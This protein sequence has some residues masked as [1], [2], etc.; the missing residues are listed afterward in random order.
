MKK[1]RALVAVTATSLAAAAAVA[2]P[3][4]ATTSDAA[5]V[6][7]PPTTNR[8]L[9]NTS[10]DQTPKPFSF[11][12]TDPAPSLSMVT[13]VE[14]FYPTAAGIV[15]PSAPSISAPPNW[16]ATPQSSPDGSTQWVTFRSNSAVLGLVPGQPT[17]FTV[18]GVVHEPAS[19]SVTGTW[20]VEDSRDGGKTLLPTTP[21]EFTTTINTLEFVTPFAPIAPAGVTDRTGTAGE[22]ITY[23]VAVRNFAANPMTIAPTVTS[24]SNDVVTQPAAQSI[25]GDGATSSFTVPVT[26]GSAGTSVFLASLPDGA[27]TVSDSFTV[28]A[29]ADLSLS[30]LGPSRIGAGGHDLTVATT[31]TGTQALQ[32]TGA[33]LSAGPIVGTATAV[34]TFGGG[35]QATPQNFTFP[36]VVA[37]STPDNDYPTTV[38]AQVTDDN[39]FSYT[40]THSPANDVIVDTTAPSVNPPVIAPPKD[41]NGVAQS[42]TKNGDTLSISGVVG[43]VT[44][45]DTSSL[46]VSITPNDGSAARPVTS[47]GAGLTPAANNTYTYACTFSGSWGGSATSVVANVQVN[48]TAGNV[49][50][51]SGNS[52]AVSID[53]IAPT[54]GPQ[55]T[56]TSSVNVQFPFLDANGDSVGFTGGCDPNDYVLNGAPAGAVAAVSGGACASGASGQRGVGFRVLTLRTPLNA[57][58][59]TSTITYQ[60]SAASRSPL[61]DGA[62]NAA[63]VITLKVVSTVKPAAP[64]FSAVTRTA[65]DGSVK[66]AVSDSAGYWGNTTGA[67]AFQVTVNNAKQYYSVIVYDAAGNVLNK[68]TVTEAPSASSA[69]TGDSTVSHTVAIPIA[70]DSVDGAYT[71]VI[72]FQ[73]PNWQYSPALTLTFNLD[74]VAPTFDVTQ[75]DGSSASASF[76]EP[77]AAGTDAAE[78]W[79][80]AY[81]DAGGN[82]QTVNVNGVSKTDDQTR[83]VTFTLPTGASYVGVYYRL[84]PTSTD[85]RYED[86]AGNVVADNLP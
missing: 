64:T 31:K 22:P 39:G 66:P 76:T 62:G 28:Q 12:I 55:A 81:T 46:R 44:D 84:D 53:N 30:T 19:A 17:T 48:D 85:T 42:E 36:V 72:K 14:V 13:Q 9:P 59:T 74:R 83:L 34:P 61:V 24:S 20:V 73:S 65:A 4:Y 37:S 52:N 43:P 8:V 40:V 57:D 11:T 16:T 35:N 23:T 25:S 26:L 47:C 41:A 75:V 27:G 70:A 18:P 56:L 58:T 82:R 49:S 15:L 50:T 45:L 86:R 67:N 80:V 1:A 21:S 3:S 5:T 78:D 38:T 77:I 51:L 71:R 79:F 2:L 10:A 60:P 69:A 6:S 68:E 54:A 33:S 32:I 29:P 63:G 7:T